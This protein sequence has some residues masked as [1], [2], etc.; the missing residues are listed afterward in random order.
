M[1]RPGEIIDVSVLLRGGMPQWDGEEL[2]E[3]ASMLATPDDDVNVTRL[4]ITTHTG[5]HVDAPRHFVH[6]GR[7]LD[8][9]PL[10]RWVGPCVVIDLGD[11][12]RDITAEDLNAAA[13]PA[14]TTRLV[15]KTS[16]SDLWKT[17]PS[18]FVQNYIALSPSGA[19]WLV[20]R[21][22][23]LVAIDYLSI[24]SVGPTGAE[25]HLTLL[26]NDVLI[27]EG[28]DLTGVPAGLYELLCFPLNIEASDGAPARVA[29]RALAP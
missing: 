13:V 27:V 21:Q 26:N 12:A 3:A 2:Y 20:E 1:P 15:L 19:E 9:I 17:H 28:L 25:T 16:N 10:D 24:G 22:I 7:T 18:E 14:N 4:T 29:L 23:R 5:T 6:E 8:E 11:V